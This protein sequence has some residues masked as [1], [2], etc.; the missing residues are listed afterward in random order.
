LT[1]GPSWDV[2]SILR[3]EGPFASRNARLYVFFNVL[4][5]ARAYY[6]VL[7]ILFTDLGLS[8]DQFVLLNL[9]WAMAIFLLEV[10]S[11]ALADTL[12]R[13]KLLIFSA[14][15]MVVEMAVLLVA[16]RHGGPWLFALCVVNRLCSGTS[17]A[18]A[19]G[20]DEA[21]AYESLPEDGRAAAWDEILSKA[22]RWR[23][24]ALLIAMGLGGLLYD[25]SWLVPM[26]GKGVLQY[27][28][29][30]HRLPIVLV[31]LQAVACCVIAFRFEE[32]F[33]PS[34]QGQGAMAQAFRTTLRTA[35]KAFSTPIIAKV[36]LGAVLIDAISR[37]FATLNSSY[38]RMIQLP[39]WSF[40]LIGAGIAGTGW[41]V[42]GMAR[43]LNQGRSPL[44]V[45]HVL[46]ILTLILLS[47]LVPAWPIIGLLPAISLMLI[48]GMIGFT[49][50][51]FLHEHAESHE[52]ATLLSVKGL[53]FNLGYGTYSFI[54]SQMLRSAGGSEVFSFS[55]A[56]AWQVGG[57]A[58]VLAGYILFTRRASRVEAGR[59]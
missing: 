14:L 26:C 10:P 42:P 16:P 17:E 25:P 6:P 13:K 39:E 57:F 1:H 41:F 2:S 28:D 37:N 12:G 35:K 27:T 29:L 59:G 32:N 15:L 8:L 51:R 56:L 36:L 43:R 21:I 31:L 11:G 9:F 47:A 44:L 50:S 5:N 4:Y 33:T 20:A 54:F 45:L 46:G 49:V 58:V 55:R 24:A 34:H 30:F 38:Y 18:S 23:S 48:L 7:A 40:G 19:S 3:H 22:T 52:R 53:I